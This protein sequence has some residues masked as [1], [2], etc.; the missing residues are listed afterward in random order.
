MP[1]N[2]LI[3]YCD[4][5]YNRP[6]RCY[7]C[8]NECKGSC[9]KCL[10][11]I[12]KTSTN[13]RTYNC[14]N[15]INC[16]TCKYLYKYSAE[17]EHLL[18]QFIRWFKLNQDNIITIGSIGCGPCSELF[19][20]DQF[21]RHNRLSFKIQYK[22]FELIN[23]WS[24][25]HNKIVEMGIVHHIEFHYEDV[26]NY[27]TLHQDYPQILI[28]N[29]VVSDIV[30]RNSEVGINSFLIKLYELIEHMSSKSF[31]VI[32]D[33]NLGRTN[34]EARYYYDIIENELQYR[35]INIDTRKYHFP[36]SQRYYYAYGLMLPNNITCHIPNDI[37]QKYNPWSECR[38]AAL[39]IY[40]R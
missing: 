31:V 36:N 33:I 24:H 15:I 4:D 19:G 28:L 9:L 22:G 16:Y 23:N 39:I 10:E 5:L 20:L 21:K 7:T 40:K 13:D 30:R 2:T 29:Y 26:F 12:H 8:S 14:N 18:M 38:S 34:R 25:I 37:M 6:T 17:I 1:I 11:Y 32:N 3:R 35:G 27:Y